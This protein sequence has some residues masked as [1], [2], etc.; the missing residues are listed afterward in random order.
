MKF[1]AGELEVIYDNLK[2]K[3]IFKM[4]SVFKQTQQIKPSF[5]TSRAATVPK[6]NYERWD[7]NQQ[8]SENTPTPST[9]GNKMNR[10]IIGPLKSVSVTALREMITQLTIGNKIQQEV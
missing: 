7:S 5:Q 10:L 3:K 9:R 4:W 2:K 1:Q 6:G 8:T